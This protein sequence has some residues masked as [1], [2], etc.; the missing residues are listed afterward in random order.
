MAQYDKVVN[1]AKLLSEP[2]SINIIRVLHAQK[3]CTLIE[4]SNGYEQSNIEGQL[5]SLHH[6]GLIN[7][8]HIHGEVYYSFNLMFWS[9][10]KMKMINFLENPT[11]TGG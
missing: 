8:E 4:L 1:V 3:R 10:A 6:S 5:Q 11:N 2:S 9:R 7:T